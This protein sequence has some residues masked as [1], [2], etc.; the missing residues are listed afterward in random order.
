[1]R[2]LVKSED[3]VKAGEQLT[4]GTINPHNILRVLGRE[5]VEHYL[6]NEIQKVYRSQAV[7][8]H[9]KHIAVIVRQMLTKVRVISSGDTELLPEELISR[10]DYE[11]VNAKVLAEGGEPAIADAVLLGITR[12][13]LLKD[14]WLA[15]ASFQET[16]HVLLS[17]AIKGKTDKLRGL[18]ENVILGKLI[19]AR[20]LEERQPVTSALAEG[21]A[22]ALLGAEESSPL[23]SPLGE[24]SVVRQVMEKG[25]GDRGNGG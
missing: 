14:S 5:A 2:L 25:E 9:D 20:A 4:E 8:I 21:N 22:Q 16:D 13:S 11:E 17:A 3:E 1:V 24:E 18:K 6:I 12:V 7:N 10:L 19:P 15:S 23:T